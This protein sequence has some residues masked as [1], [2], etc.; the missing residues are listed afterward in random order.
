MKN[1]LALLLLLAFIFSCGESSKKMAILEIDEKYNE[2]NVIEAQEKILAYLN[3][4]QDNEYAWTLSGHIHSELDQD[5][6]AIRDYH[7]ALKIN[8]ETEEALTG[9]GILY[10][11]QK[12]Y[13]KAVE[14]YQKAL[15]INPKYAQA[16]ASLVVIEL[17]RKN[18]EKAVDY[19]EKGYRLEPND[20]V[21]AANLSAAY[22]FKGDTTNRD[23]Y[24]Q[25]AKEMGYAGAE[26]LQLIFDGSL[27]LY[28]E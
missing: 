14:Y 22:H 7:E 18:Y 24:F 20:P 26:T 1:I 16:Y 4:K 27:D 25:L 2:G 10:R 5:S 19:G 21:I 3:K 23:K 28:S 6:L 12:D 15:E 11:K 9:L 8:Q 17:V 13:D